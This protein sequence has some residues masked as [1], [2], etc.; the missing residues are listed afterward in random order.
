MTKVV[1]WGKQTNFLSIFAKYCTVTV[2]KMLKNALLQCKNIKFV[3]LGT[4]HGA[5]ISQLSAINSAS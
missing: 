2:Q 1:Y 3:Q 5:I 4:D